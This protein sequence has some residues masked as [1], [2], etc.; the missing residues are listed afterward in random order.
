MDVGRL[1]GL[2]CVSETVAYAQVSRFREQINCWLRMKVL[3]NNSTLMTIRTD[4]LLVDI[5]FAQID[6]I[7]KC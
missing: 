5:L 6:F 3:A 7:K 1:P 2:I 4:V